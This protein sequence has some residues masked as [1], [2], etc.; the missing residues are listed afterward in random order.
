MTAFRHREF[1]PRKRKTAD[2]S[3][4]PIRPC[5]HGLL[6]CGN[7][8][9]LRGRRTMRGGVQ[10]GGSPHPP[11]PAD[12][13]GREGRSPQATAC[14][15]PDSDLAQ[16]RFLEVDCRKKETN[17]SYRASFS[18]SDFKK[19]LQIIK[20]IHFKCRKMILRGKEK[21]EVILALKTHQHCW[22]HPEVSRA[23]F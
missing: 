10:G 16:T 1:L 5:T 7:M 20:A 4:P 21:H 6:A 18:N 15:D 11:E 9:E 22:P 12:A 13:K 19:Y 3:H 17:L 23:P 2:S 8:A 14:R